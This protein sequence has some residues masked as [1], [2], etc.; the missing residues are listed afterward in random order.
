MLRAT[1]YNPS[2]SEQWDSFVRAARNGVFLFERGYMDYHSA[3]FDDASMMIWRDSE[4]IAVLPAH[5]DADEWISHGGLSFGGLVLHP[6]CGARAVLE[7]VDV[8]L[9][10]LRASGARCLTYRP[11]PHIFHRQP[12]EDD[13][14]ALHR[15]G[16]K[17]VRIDL[18]SVIDLARRT[19]LSKGRRHA[20]AKAH[21]NGVTVREGR[22]F[23]TFW[24]LLRARLM[25]QHGVTPTHDEAEI[26]LLADRF[27]QIKL[28]CAYLGEAILA[29]VITFRYDGVLHT[30]YM[31]A[32]DTGRE[33]GA[34]DLVI[35]HLI[36]QASAEQLRW[37][38][39]GASTYDN[40]RQLNEGLVA[41][42]EMFGGRSAV[43]QTLAI[44]LG[45]E[46]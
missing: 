41:Q 2:F 46:S 27:S 22:D 3:R 38:S 10:T 5:R 9:D 11:V 15:H 7:I 6:R 28:H 34:L 31:A 33:T 32:S 4:L 37:L 42:K 24:S 36:D 35:T 45:G 23:Q 12:S 43:L 40:G 39:F 16:A 19:T 30:Q 17:A 25:V 21:R 20:L 14:Y 44:D 1:P 8:L 18:S 13:L 29:G 26:M